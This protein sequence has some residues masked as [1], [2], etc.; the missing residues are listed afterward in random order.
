MNKKNAFIAV[1]LPSLGMAIKV[2]FRGIYAKLA[3]RVSFHAKLL[4]QRVY[5]V[6]MFL[7]S[8]PFINFVNGTG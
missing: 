2:I 8:K 3:A 6:I 1:L 4:I 5:G 7:V